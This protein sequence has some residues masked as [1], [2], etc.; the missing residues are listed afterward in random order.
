[1]EPA[2]PD[3]LR[4]LAP[5]GV[6]RAAINLGNPVLAR[7]VPTSGEPI[8]AS[9]DLARELGRRLGVPVKLV[10]FD[11]A[12][13]VFE[14]VMSNTLDV[15]FLAIDLT[16]AAEI[17][18]TAPYVTIEGTYIVRDGSSFHAI[19][20]FDRPGVRIAVG[21][22]AAYDLFLTRT[23]KH[24]E[25][26][27][28]DTSS[29]AVELF[30]EVGLDA[31]AGVRQPLFNYARTHQGVRVIDGRFTTIEQAMGTPNGRPGA[32][33]YLQLFV[34]AMKAGGFVAA[35]LERSGQHEAGVAPLSVLEVRQTKSRG[36][37]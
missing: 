25:L 32:R 16:R 1:M 33:Q 2:S 19:E 17:L 29:G 9:V 18:F 31:A 12:G 8:G 30:V 3:V 20:D 5:T 7:K 28:S 37:V 10:M 34:E 4:E 23:L 21:K 15:V 22:G 36:N 35:A 24:A 27:R 26:V 6:L 13:K 11:A 14:A